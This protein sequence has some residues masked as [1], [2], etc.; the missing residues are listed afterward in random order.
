MARRPHP[1]TVVPGVKRQCWRSKPAGWGVFEAVRVCLQKSESGERT[2]LCDAARVFLTS[3]RQVAENRY[4]YLLFITHGHIHKILSS[5][6]I[7]IVLK[8]LKQKR[9]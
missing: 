7:D 5:L 4:A 8:S 2:G 1:F 3:Q 9:D 6:S